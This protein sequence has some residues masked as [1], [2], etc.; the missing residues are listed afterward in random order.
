MLFHNY[1][2][3][4]TRRATEPENC[5][6]E[7]GEAGPVRFFDALSAL[8]QLGGRPGEPNQPNQRFAMLALARINQQR[9]VRTRADRCSKPSLKAQTGIKPWVLPRLN[10]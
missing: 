5:E 9:S 1:K 7:S 8:E 2:K 4:R 6:E 10:P 3:R